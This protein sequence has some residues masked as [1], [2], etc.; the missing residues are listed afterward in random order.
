MGAQW[1]YV[2]QADNEISFA[3]GDLIKVDNLDSGWWYATA[4][5]G[6][7]GFVWGEYV[8][9]NERPVARFDFHGTPDNGDALTAVVM[10]MQPEAAMQR[11]F[12]HR[13][14]DGLNFKDTT[15]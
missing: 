4:A 9:L 3:K 5:S 6:K 14:E 2:A 11:K 10:L 13:K 12:N 7:Q 1:D 8:A 15:Y